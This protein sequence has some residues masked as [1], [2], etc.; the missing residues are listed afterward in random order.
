MDYTEQ[1][2]ALECHKTHTNTQFYKDQMKAKHV[3]AK[4]NNV[5]FTVGSIP[6]SDRKI[7]ILHSSISEK[8]HYWQ[9]EAVVTSRF[10]Q[11]SWH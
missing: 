3:V 5:S 11:T 8:I 6:Q 9:R 10:H 4:I 1:M 7:R 2:G